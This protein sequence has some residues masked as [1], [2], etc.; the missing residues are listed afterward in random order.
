MMGL[1]VFAGKMVLLICYCT[2][3][4]ENGLLIHVSHV[5][6]KCEKG[7]PE[8]L[9]RDRRSAACSEPLGFPYRWDNTPKSILSV[10]LVPI[11]KCLGAGENYHI[12][13]FPFCVSEDGKPNP[14]VSAS[15][16]ANVNASPS[17]QIG[18]HL[19]VR[20]KTKGRP[21]ADYTGSV[22]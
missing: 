10:L 18:Y 1:Y 9:T 14:A 22:E 4:R 13:S 7:N 11:R 2:E 6:S 8:D 12:A 20:T 17:Q 21:R 5:Q 19:L 3:V 16:V 15:L